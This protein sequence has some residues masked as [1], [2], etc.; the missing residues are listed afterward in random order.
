[1]FQIAVS[2][3]CDGISTF[4]GIRKCEQ[5]PQNVCDYWNVEYGA[6][7]S[8]LIINIFLGIFGN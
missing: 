4:W 2:L 8:K 3:I 1:M 7:L 6:Y 5:V